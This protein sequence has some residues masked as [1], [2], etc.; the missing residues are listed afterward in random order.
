MDEE[1]GCYAASEAMEGNGMDGGQIRVLLRKAARAH[2]LKR[3][4]GEVVVHLAWLDH[5]VEKLELRASLE[6]EHR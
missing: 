4:E 3:P 6:H 2:H 5:I 1:G